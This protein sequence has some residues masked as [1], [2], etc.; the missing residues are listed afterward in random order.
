VCCDTNPF[1]TDSA[2]WIIWFSRFPTVHHIAFVADVR[3]LSAETSHAI[4]PLLSKAHPSLKRVEFW[5]STDHINAY[6][7]SPLERMIEEELVGSHRA[8][9]RTGATSW[10]YVDVKM[11]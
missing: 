6:A 2:D 5:S 3:L 7:K 1:L 8:F 4:Y 9:V 10:A 11:P